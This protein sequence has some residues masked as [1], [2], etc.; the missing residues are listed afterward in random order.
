MRKLLGSLAIFLISSST[1]FAQSIQWSHLL[2]Q[3][4]INLVAKDSTESTLSVFKSRLFL[5][6]S[7]HAVSKETG[8]AFFEHA[9]FADFK[10]A[11]QVAQIIFDLKAG[12]RLLYYI[13]L[14]DEEN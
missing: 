2:L 11:Q 4:E 9:Y 6:D 10:K 8:V 14:Y 1:I 5:Y 7:L 12:S 13:K 3:A